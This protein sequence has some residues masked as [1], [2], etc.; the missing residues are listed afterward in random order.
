M[1]RILSFEQSKMISQLNREFTL[2][3]EGWM[4][5]GSD[6][7]D[8]TLCNVIYNNDTNE[9]F[10]ADY[11]GNILDCDIHTVSMADMKD[12]ARLRGKISKI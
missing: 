6:C 3:Y 9:W 7:P 10:K 11:D 4:C 5:E 8:G 12:M 2:K 1:A